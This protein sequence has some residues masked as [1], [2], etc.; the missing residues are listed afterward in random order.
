MTELP[1]KQ[2]FFF[3]IFFVLI[4]SAQASD[5]IDNKDG[6]IS[7]IR[8]GLMW[9]KAD[10]GV[11]RIWTD[12]VAYC[13]SLEMAGHDDWIL[14]NIY[15]LE[16]LIDTGYSPTIN[17]IFSVKKSYYWSSSVSR[18]NAKSAKYVNFFYGN[19][20]ASFVLINHEFSAKH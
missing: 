7:D 5:F 16:G 13:E 3:L 15:M 19:T 8:N 12:T 6:T 20:Y 11:E 17:P 14:P 1:L 18:N 4:S 2:F 9:Q 10:D